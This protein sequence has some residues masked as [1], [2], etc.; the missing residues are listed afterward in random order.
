M[1]VKRS[2]S[3]GIRPVRDAWLWGLTAIVGIMLVLIGVADAREADGSSSPYLMVG[4]FPALLAPM[5]FVYHVRKIFVVRDMRRGTTAIARWTVSAD[6]YRLFCEA[7]A[8]FGAE[9]FTVNFYEPLRTIPT[10]GVEV[11]FASD[12]VLIGNGYF[13][14]STTRGRRVHRVRT[15]YSTPPML[16]FGTILETR[17]STSSVT[18]A[19]V[20][21][22]ETLRVP[23][24]SDAARAA[25]NVL[26]QFSIAI[27][28]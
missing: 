22:S 2:R 21:T 3:R 15:I 17:A 18:S 10:D 11:I 9:T 23:I 13:P 16:E 14:L 6:E 19:P 7:D 8:R 4:L 26:R 24:A 27:A 1:A 25:D 12:G 5:A 20:R 28:R